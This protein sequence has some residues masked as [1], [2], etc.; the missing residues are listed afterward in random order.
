MGGFGGVGVGGFKPAGVKVVDGMR[1]LNR[2]SPTGEKVHVVKIFSSVCVCVCLYAPDGVIKKIKKGKKVE[3]K[4]SGWWRR[5]P[6]LS[7]KLICE[8][9]AGSIIQGGHE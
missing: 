1:G 4:D 2:V 7:V 8:S 3:I 9:V 5:N 6:L